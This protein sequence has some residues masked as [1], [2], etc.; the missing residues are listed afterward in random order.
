MKAIICF[1]PKASQV[2]FLLVALSNLKVP[3]NHIELLS[4]TP[5]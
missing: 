5:S 4:I 2:E 1:Y 3:K